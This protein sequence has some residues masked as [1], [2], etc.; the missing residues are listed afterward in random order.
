M[1]TFLCCDADMSKASMDTVRG[2]LV[3]MYCET[4]ADRRWSFNGEAALDARALLASAQAHPTRHLMLVR[5]IA[6]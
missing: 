4:C 2:R 5:P 3:F 1:T 6:A